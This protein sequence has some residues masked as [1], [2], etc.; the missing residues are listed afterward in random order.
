MPLFAYWNYA[1]Y[2]LGEIEF[3]SA[4]SHDYFGPGGL[5]SVSGDIMDYTTGDTFL[6]GQTTVTDPDSPFIGVRIT[7]GLDGND[8]VAA[9]VPAAAWLFV[10]GIIALIG[11]ARHKA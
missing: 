2:A 11:F 6:V 9:P 4:A 1:T 3:S 8:P 10:S 7:I 5:A